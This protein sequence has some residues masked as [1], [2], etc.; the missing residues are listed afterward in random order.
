MRGSAGAR[1]T[2]ENVKHASVPGVAIALL[3]APARAV[4]PYAGLHIQQWRSVLE[5]FLSVIIRI[6]KLFLENALPT[7]ILRTSETGS[8][9]AT[10]AFIGDS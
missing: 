4:I 5:G 2:H 1:R 8:A 3:F 10:R 7:C 6:R 9:F